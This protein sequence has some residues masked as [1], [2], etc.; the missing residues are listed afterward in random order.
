MSEPSTSSTSDSRGLAWLSEDGTIVLEI[1][2]EDGLYENERTFLEFPPEAP[3]YEKIIA[4]V[5]PLTTDENRILTAGDV[6]AI[7]SDN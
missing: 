6:E 5:G 2:I 4:V 1:K 7:F 3:E